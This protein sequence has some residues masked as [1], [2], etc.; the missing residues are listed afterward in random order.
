VIGGQ[1]IGRLSC[2]ADREPG[3]GTEVTNSR[4]YVD[5]MA[6]SCLRTMEISATTRFGSVGSSIGCK[7]LSFSLP[8]NECCQ[9]LGS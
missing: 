8:M 4:P 5:L 9:T 2:V 3:K 6:R 1:R 7:R